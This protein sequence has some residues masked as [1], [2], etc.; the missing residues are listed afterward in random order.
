MPQVNSSF[1]ESLIK[2]VDKIAK[3]N[4]ESRSET[5]KR[6]TELGL[7]VIN[8]DYI[9]KPS[10]PDIYNQNPYPQIPAF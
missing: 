5:I 1:K 8:G 7:Q 4:G 6:L 2:K 10:P 3:K 9:R